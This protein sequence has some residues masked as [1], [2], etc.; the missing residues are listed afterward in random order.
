MSPPSWGIQMG[1]G[2]CSP[3]SPS[4]LRPGFLSLPSTPTRAPARSGLGVFDLWDQTHE[5]EPLMER[6]ESGKDL[7]AKIYS[8]LSKENSLDRVDSSVPSPG[9]DFGWVLELVK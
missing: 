5:E 7:R 3:R 2:Y 6:V 8:K 1:S 4:P 9:P